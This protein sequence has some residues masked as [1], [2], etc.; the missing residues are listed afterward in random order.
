MRL[1]PLIMPVLTEEVQI[2]TE[3]LL[4]LRNLFMEGHPPF[5]E[6]FLQDIVEPFVPARQ[7][8]GHPV[9]FREW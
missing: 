4:A 3:I 1:V 2:V 8:L 9:V 5:P 6:S 7:V